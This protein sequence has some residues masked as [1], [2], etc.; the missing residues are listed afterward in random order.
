M[1]VTSPSLSVV[2]SMEGLYKAIA[3]GDQSYPCKD[4][5]AAISECKSAVENRTDADSLD[6]AT[7]NSGATVGDGISC[8]VESE[9]VKVTLENQDLWKQFN[10]ITN[11]MIVTKAGRYV[12]IHSAP[13]NNEFLSIEYF[14]WVLMTCL[15]IGSYCSVLWLYRRMFPLLQLSLSGLEPSSSYALLIQFELARTN[16]WRFLNGEWQGAGSGCM[17]EPPEEGCIYIHH[18]SPLTGDQWMKEKVTFSKLKLS[19]KENGKGKVH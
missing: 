14:K 7:P 2:V 19:N 18:S 5:H 3:A 1:L 12:I 6:S 10:D 17:G 15:C 4:F 16:R 9:E 8:I 11:E 13:A